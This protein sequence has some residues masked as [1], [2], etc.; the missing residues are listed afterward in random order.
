MEKR[1]FFVTTY[2]NLSASL[3]AYILNTHPD[4]HCHVSLNDPFISNDNS[5]RPAQT[6]DKFITLNSPKR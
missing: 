1:F 4:I 2:D 3:I 6:V 5:G